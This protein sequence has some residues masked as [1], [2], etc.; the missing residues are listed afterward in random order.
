MAVSIQSKAIYAEKNNRNYFFNGHFFP[1]TI[2]QS[3]R[4]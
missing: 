3:R 1:L 4:K 2:G